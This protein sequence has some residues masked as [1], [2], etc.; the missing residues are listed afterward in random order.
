M[1]QVDETLFGNQKKPGSAA[2]GSKGS[3]KG[4]QPY[5]TGVQTNA[6]FISMDELRTIRQK[7]EKNN[8]ND[9]VVISQRD[10]DRIKDATTIKTKDQ[11]LQEKRLADQ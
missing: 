2:G 3:T 5:P 9:A 11:L 8:Q 6:G 1:S 4:K 7:T 10:L